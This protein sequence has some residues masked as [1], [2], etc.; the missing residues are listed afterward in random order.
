MLQEVRGS[1]QQELNQ[2]AKLRNEIM[3]FMYEAQQNI[4]KLEDQVTS[5]REQTDEMVRRVWGDVEEVGKLRRR[6]RNNAEVESK[7]MQEQ[8]STVTGTS[9]DV[10]KSLE[11][12]SSVIWM[13]V[14]SERAASALDCQD[15][16][17]RGRV[18]LMGYREPK[19]K[20]GGGGKPPGPKQLRDKLSS[21]SPTPSLGGD[22]KGGG[23]G[24]PV[25]SVDNRCLSCSG[26]A[27]TVLSGFKMACLQYAPGPVKFAKKTYDRGD[28]L[29]LREKLLDQAHESLLQGPVTFTK[30]DPFDQKD[31]AGAAPLREALHTREGGQSDAPTSAGGEFPR[32]PDS[33][34]S[35]GSTPTGVRMPP[36]SARGSAMAR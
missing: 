32:R 17:D 11:H 19:D 15:D 24:G 29:D 25:I 13:L 36:L 1:Y 14:Q 9:E 30:A 12:I 31:G 28:L 10:A 21:P 26:Q 22:E 16:S 2:S 5:S 23:V 8:L 7:S 20:G 3:T 27:Q 6:D 34:S 4:T 18:A 33:R 35:S